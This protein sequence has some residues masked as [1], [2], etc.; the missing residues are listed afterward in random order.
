MDSRFSQEEASGHQCT[1]SKVEPPFSADSA[2]QKIGPYEAKA[3][4][5]GVEAFAETLKALPILHVVQDQN[6]EHYL[7]ILAWPMES[8][9]KRS[10]KFCILGMENPN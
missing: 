3:L 10:G 1:S 6:R 9:G 7:F 2:A 8:I 4:R 5:R